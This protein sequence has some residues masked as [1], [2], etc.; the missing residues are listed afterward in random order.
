MSIDAT[1]TYLIPPC[2]WHLPQRRPN[3][4]F[5]V[6]AAGVEESAIDF[7]HRQHPLSAFLGTPPPQSQEQFHEYRC[8]RDI[9]YTGA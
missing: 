6:G 1:G 7:W 8:A 9:P 5:K 3:K 4:R 2:S